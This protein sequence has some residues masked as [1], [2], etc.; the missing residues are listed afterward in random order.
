MIDDKQLYRNKC[1]YLPRKGV[2]RVCTGLITEAFRKS[3]NVS[4]RDII[5][6]PG[7]GSQCSWKS[8]GLFCQDCGLSY[9]Q[10]PRGKPEEEILDE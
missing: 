3:C 2:C 6:G 10:L 4:D 7:Y 9:H 5:I 1:P 8:S